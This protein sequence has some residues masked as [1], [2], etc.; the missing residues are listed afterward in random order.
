MVLIL[1][2]VPHVFAQ[3]RLLLLVVFH[4]LLSVH[5]VGR[6]FLLF[7]VEIVYR[8]VGFRGVQ[9][10]ERLHSHN[11]R[12]DLPHRVLCQQS[13]VYHAFEGLGVACKLLRVKVG[14]R[15]IDDLNIA[16]A[17]LQSIAFVV[18]LFV[19]HRVIF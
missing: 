7:V 10:A 5:V 13:A 11:V 4:E 12:L 8:C 1:V 9:P 18:E 2:K 17:F 15:H 16:A 6:P 19:A 3:P 14:E